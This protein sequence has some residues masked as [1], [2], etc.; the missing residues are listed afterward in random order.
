MASNSLNKFDDRADEAIILV[1]RKHSDSTTYKAGI[2]LLAAAW[3]IY[4]E[5]LIKE[6]ASFIAN[7]APDSS[8]IPLDLKR[9]ICNTNLNPEGRQKHDHFAWLFTGDLWREEVFQYIVR[10]VEILN[11]PNSKNVNELFLR[12]LNHPKISFCWGR[13]RMD[14]DRAADTLD[15][16]LDLRHSIAH[17]AREDPLIKADVQR[18]RQ[19]L[20]ITVRNTEREVSKYLHS[21]I[22]I[23]PW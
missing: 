3:E 18:F 9:R 15:E 16:W 11:T 23:K 4:L 19:F 5:F 13:Q 2:V 1:E 8:V 21:K 20:E 22:G 14:N 17:G 7:K 12:T 6:A 10:Q